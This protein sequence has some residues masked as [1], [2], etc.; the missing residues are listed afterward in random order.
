MWLNAKH[1]SEISIIKVTKTCKR[2]K[3][4]VEQHLKYSS[5]KNLMIA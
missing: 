4:Y 1:N 3:Q 2:N 5:F